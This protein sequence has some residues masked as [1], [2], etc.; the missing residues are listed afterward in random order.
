MVGSSVAD[1]KHISRLE[2]RFQSVGHRP[3]IDF[4]HSLSSR[5]S[6]AASCSLSRWAA[7]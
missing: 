7:E 1:W 4:N 2:R 3:D 5:S 6:A